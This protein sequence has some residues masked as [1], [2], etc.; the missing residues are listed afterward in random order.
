MTDSNLSAPSERQ[1]LH[2]SAEAN[3]HPHLSHLA[4][5]HHC[6]FSSYSLLLT[7]NADIESSKCADSVIK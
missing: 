6:L 7:L 5:L 1:H 3:K 4:Y 2:L